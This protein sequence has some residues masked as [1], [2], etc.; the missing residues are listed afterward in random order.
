MHTEVY[1]G[2]LKTQS[3][4]QS[5][6][7]PLGNPLSNQPWITYNTTK[8]VTLIPSRHTLPLVQHNNTKNAD[9]DPLKKTQHFSAK[10]T[11]FLSTDTKD[12]TCYKTNM[13]SI[14]DENP[15]SHSLIN[16]ISK[17]FSTF[18]KSQSLEKLKYVF[19]YIFKVVV[20]Y[21]ILTNY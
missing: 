9:L 20:C 2:S 12:Y 7:K 1:T 10:H 13:K 17:Q 18:Q 15:I 6:H 8:V 14:Q 11:K 21:Q 3:Y 5:S 16:A 19:L 4:I